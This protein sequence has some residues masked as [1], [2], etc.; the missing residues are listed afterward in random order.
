MAAHHADD[1]GAEAGT[2]VE[3][4]AE[5][6]PQA[7]ESRRGR[8]RAAA[9]GRAEAEAAESV[10]AGRDGSA[11]A[12]SETVSTGSTSTESP[13]EPVVQAE[14]G[15]TGR[16]GAQRTSSSAPTAPAEAQ[17][18]R[19]GPEAEPV[20]HATGA[21]EQAEA[22]PAEQVPEAGG[23]RGRRRVA[24]TAS[25]VS[26]DSRGAVFVLT[27]A[28]QDSAP[29]FTLDELAPAEVTPRQR[30]RRR[31]AGRAAGAPESPN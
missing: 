5:S 3:A 24:R 14:P 10:A 29:K 20:Q 16:V 17:P 9:A 2:P 28:D 1:E 25:P 23:R 12:G 26:T 4:K 7:K 27:D 31:A 21:A 15:V 6:K 30:T 22:K 19:Q 13:A 11:S 8:A 18:V